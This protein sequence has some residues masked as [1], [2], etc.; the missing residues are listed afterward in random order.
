[1]SKYQLQKTFS[2]D[3]VEY[4]EFDLNF[5]ALTGK[6]IVSAEAQYRAAGNDESVFVKEMNKA[7][8]AYV[9]ASAAKVMPDAIL[10]LPAK[11]F[12]KVTNKARNFLLLGV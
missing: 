1:M 6:D 11:E 4:N 12:V 8:L 9:V 2:F 5:E 7:F 10:N 3:G